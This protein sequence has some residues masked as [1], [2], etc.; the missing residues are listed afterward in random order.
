MAN[1][2]KQ[3]S[4]WPIIL[5]GAGFILVAG[6]VVIFLNNPL[7]PSV[8]TVPTQ[9]LNQIPFPEIPRVSLGDAKAA[10]DL[11]T[12][13]FIDVRG[14]PYFSQGHIPGA[15]S[16]TSAELSSR[17]SELDPNSWVITYCT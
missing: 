4:L 8:F 3:L 14:E 10:Y 13:V 1:R 6:A 15:L 11:K 12:A 9:V 17:M 5:V 7:Q 16:I 2:R